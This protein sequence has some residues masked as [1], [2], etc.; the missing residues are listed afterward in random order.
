MERHYHSE[1]KKAG[2]QYHPTVDDML[3]KKVGKPS[4]V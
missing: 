2:G 1:S 4:T 3:V